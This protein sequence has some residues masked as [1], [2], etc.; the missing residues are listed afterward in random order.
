M[1][2]RS[3]SEA[4]LLSMN[5]PSGIALALRIRYLTREGEGSA[6]GLGVNGL[7]KGLWWHSPGWSWEGAG[8]CCFLRGC[9][10]LLLPVQAPG[11]QSP[12]GSQPG[13]S[14]TGGGGV[15]RTQGGV[16]EAESREPLLLGGQGHASSWPS[17]REPRR[18]LTCT[19]GQ[20]RTGTYLHPP[21]NWAVLGRV[22]VSVEGQNFPMDSTPTKGS[23]PETRPSRTFSCSSHRRKWNIIQWLVWQRGI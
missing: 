22:E 7:E 18:R 14:G 17:T 10:F 21:T 16:W 1:E 9:C 15:S 5:C 6:W 8:P 11:P 12:V 3:F 20:V 23:V 4:F 19:G 13:L 2:F